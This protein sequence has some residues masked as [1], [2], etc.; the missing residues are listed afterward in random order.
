MKN[1]IKYLLTLLRILI[2]WHFLYE[3]LVKLFSKGWTSAAYLM[4][5]QW[6]CSGIF[7]KIA[8]NDIALQIVDFLNI[9]GLIILGICLFAGLFIRLSSATGAFLLMLYYIANPPFIGFI[10]E[11]STEG[12]YLIVNKVLIE[13]V[14]LLILAFLPSYATFGID[15]I[16]KRIRGKIRSANTSAG[17]EIEEVNGNKGRRE[18]LKDLVALPFLGGFA[19]AALR[20]KK[21]ESFEERYLISEPSRVDAISGASPAGTGFASLKELEGTVPKGKIGEFEI[22]RLMAGGNLISGYAHSRDLIY[23]S[24]LVQSYFTDEKVIETMNLCEFCGIN[25]IILRVDVNTLRIMEKYR[26]RGGKM[27]W[28]AQCKIKENEIEPDINAAFD[29]GAM[30]AYIHG[31]VC[32]QLVRK[33]KTDILHDTIK[34]IKHKGILAGIAGHDLQVIKSCEEFGVDPDFYMKTLN[35]G[36]YWTAGPRLITDP[37]WK[38]MPKEIIEPEYGSNIKDN[39]WSITPQQT[40]EYMKSVRKPWIAYKVLGAGA[41]DPLDGLRYAFEN[42]ADFCCVGMFDFQ[43]VEDTNI[44]INL[45]KENIQRKRSWYS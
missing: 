10:G 18:L 16:Y 24:N 6:L 41:I 39:I 29:N 30:A 15:R 1:Y 40:I 43:V 28:I 32:D 25:S 33:N 26:K 4:E 23:V 13:T 17:S 37:D 27:H 8:S 19:F 44:A 5:S 11:T 12:Q 34:Y 21:W 35:S 7:H 42:G 22:S 20:K 45:L 9:W 36:N 2:G 14:V 38:P 3:G 31:G